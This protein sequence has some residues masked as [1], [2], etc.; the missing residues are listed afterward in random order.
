[1][2]WAVCQLLI[3]MFDEDSNIQVVIRP[4][5]EHVVSV[6]LSG[7]HHSMFC[8]MFLVASII[9]MAGAV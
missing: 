7:R 2:K 9:S 4:V 6:F 1:M 3:R 8:S 5:F